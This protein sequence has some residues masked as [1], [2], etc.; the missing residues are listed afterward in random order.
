MRE[1]CG[2]CGETYHEE[3]LATC[4]VCG[5]EFCYRCGDMAGGMCQ[6]CAKDDRAMKER[7]KERN[8]S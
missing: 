2:V 8:G 7:P 6:R 4:T 3:N 5:R 1:Y